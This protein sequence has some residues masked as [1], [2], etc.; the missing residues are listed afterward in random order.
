MECSHP[1][2]FHI[3]Y[4]CFHIGTGEL[5]CCKGKSSLCSVAFYSRNLSFLAKRLLYTWP[6]PWGLSFVSHPLRGLLSQPQPHP[7]PWSRVSL[8]VSALDCLCELQM[9]RHSFCGLL[10]PLSPPRAGYRLVNQ[11]PLDQAGKAAHFV[12]CLEQ[13]WDFSTE[14]QRHLFQAREPRHRALTSSDLARETK[15]GHVHLF[16]SGCFSQLA[17]K[18]REAFQRWR[19]RK[20]S[21]F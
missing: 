3:V 6:T 5:G 10:L 19:Q 20:R 18:T 13:S 9:E 21:S 17:V 7:A 16:V 1:I 15:K 11:P 12:L 4:S 14:V 2:P 8:I